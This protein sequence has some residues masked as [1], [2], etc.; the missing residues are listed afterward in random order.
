MKERERI[1]IR[2][3]I[4]L[5]REE[6]TSDPIFKEYSFTNVK[7]EHDRTTALLVRE[8]YSTRHHRHPSKIALMNAAIFRFHGTIETARHLGWSEI[9]GGPD[10]L[11]ART[12]VLMATGGRVFTP[13]YIVPN[14]GDDR[15]KT[16]VVADIVNGIVSDANFILDT[17]SW[18]EACDRMCECFGVGAFMAKEVLLDYILA[19]Q[20][21]PKDWETWTPIG[22]GAL[23]GAGYVRYGQPSKIN[24]E[25]ALEVVRSLYSRREELWPPDYVKLDL[26]DIQFQLCEIAKYMRFRLGLGRPKRKFRP[27]QDGVTTL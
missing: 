12:D 2:R 22:P 15:P 5:P 6:W 3:R 1:R 14:C 25:E 27:T 18:E 13:A 23:R 17:N 19:T 21:K 24:T 7:R 8:F 9:W 26:T 16:H 11:R 20:W 10:I 4:G